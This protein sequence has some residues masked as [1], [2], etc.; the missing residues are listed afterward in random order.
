MSFSS[1]VKEEL[2]RHLGKSRHCQI[3]E[4][5]ALIAFDGKVQVSESGCDLFLDSENELLNT[6]Y[7]LLLK[8]LFDF[9]EE[10]REKSGREQKKIYETVKMWDE[11]H[12]IPMITETVNGLLLLQGCCKRAY[13]RGAFLAGGSISDPNKSYH[14]EIV[15]RTM[16]QAEQLRDTMN[17]FDVDAKIVERKKHFVVYL[18]EGAQIVDILNVMEAHVAL[19]N[20]ENVRILKEMRNSVNRKVNCETANISKT[21]NA[22]VKQLEDITYIREVMGL[23]SLPDN[24]KEMALLRLEYPEAPL[25]ELGMYL[26]PPVGKSG[27]NHRLRKISEIADG[28][29]EEEENDKTRRK[30]V[31]VQMD[32]GMEARPIA[33]MV[34]TANQFSSHLYLEMDGKHVNA[35]SIMGMMSLVLTNGVVV[36]IDAEGTDEVEAVE[37]LE[38]LLTGK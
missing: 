3:A 1:E 37:A 26:D 27:V 29:R 30:T 17:S 5:A 6:K 12:Q 9:S 32:A 4:L 14:F 31:E 15:C 2:S 23:D 13:I 34:Q 38:R 33:L 24:L 22:A 19:M 11:D 28:L 25:K 21:V 16:P 18:K 10:K 8:K 20:L 7:D 36:T 35:K